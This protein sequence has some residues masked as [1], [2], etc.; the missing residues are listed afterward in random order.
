MK[1]IKNIFLACILFTITPIHTIIF[2]SNNLHDLYKYAD[3]NT[4][5]VFDMDDT[6]ITPPGYVGSSVWLEHEIKNLQK[7]GFAFGQA[8]T[9]L[10]PTYFIIQKFIHLKAIGDSPAV[11]ATLQNKDICAMIL[12][13]RSMPLKDITISELK[14]LGIDL[15]VNCL[16]KDDINLDIT[17]KGKFSH[18]IIF[19]AN[20]DKGQILFL[21]LEK[22]G[23]LPKKIIFVDD[24]LKYVKA[25]ERETEK[26]NIEF[27]GI[28]YCRQDKYKK[29]FDPSIANKQFHQLKISMGIEALD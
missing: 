23:Y 20:N 8:L 16:F 11:I 27:V 1:K 22:I 12:T 13:N 19:A 29:N 3:K 6:L 9:F 4:L 14:R 28:R 15:S 21:F 17:H 25:V 2:E 10:L 7:K 18:G 24:K 26:R 5:V